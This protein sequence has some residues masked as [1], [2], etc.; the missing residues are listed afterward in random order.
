MSARTRFVLFAAAL[1]AAALG[2]H[3][4]WADT[5]APD[6]RAAFASPHGKPQGPSYQT[7]TVN[8][9]AINRTVSGI[10]V[11]RPLVSVL[12]GSQLSG[13]IAEIKADFNSEVRAGDVLAVL[14]DQLLATRVAQAEAELEMAR[15][16]LATGESSLAKALAVVR[17][18][19]GTLNRQQ[20]LERGS[21]TTK[22]SVDN[23]T[24]DLAVARSEAEVARAQ[25]KNAMATIRHR[26]AVLDQAKIDLERTRIRAPIGGIVI[27]RMVEQG[28]T[29]AASLQSPELFRIAQDLKRMNIEAQISEADIASVRYGNAATVTV[30]AHPETVFKGV[31]SQVRLSPTVDQNVV[32]Y[33]VVIGIDN[34]SLQLLP[35]MTAN[36]KIETER[37]VNVVRV[38][39][40]ALRYRSA[41]AVSPA[42]QHSSVWMLDA[43]GSERA[44]SVR[45]GLRD[46]VHVEVTGGDIAEGMQVITRERRTRTE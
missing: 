22:A 41:K 29:V 28:Q 6:L 34:A 40:D 7:A 12:V 43:D 3:V 19:E 42:D 35:G 11:A 17:Q 13:Q 33:T 10:G 18:S 20:I 15:A 27:S 30:E 21:N 8:R 23:A 45:T 37:R 39:L 16:T 4:K 46:D 14:D 31:V 38:P 24:R 1:P 32:T 25:I 9:G 44:L 2:I 5:G 26:E 36:V